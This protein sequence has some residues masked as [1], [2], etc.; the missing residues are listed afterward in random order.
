MS[1]T[2]KKTNR[3]KFLFII[4]TIS[5][6]L[7]SI[8][9]AIN[10]DNKFNN[11]N[12]I[13]PAIAKIELSEPSTLGKI[14]NHGITILDRDETFVSI[15]A[16]DD[17]LIWL[18]NEG[19]EPEILYKDYAEMM[20][21]NTNPK[22]LEDF[23]TYSQMTTDLQGIS[24]TYSDIAQLYNLGSSVQGRTI[25]G[26]KI[27]DNPLIEENEPEVRICGCHHGNEIMS[28]ELSLNLAFYMVE[29]YEND[30]YIKDLVD[31]RE[32]WIIPMVNPDGRESLSRYNAHGVDLNR[33]YGY[34]WDGEGGSPG[35]FSQPETQAIR[36]NALE[37]NFVFSLS[38]HTTANYINYIW[39]YKGQPVKDHNVV[40]YLSQKYGQYNDYIVV[41]GY[42]WYQTRGDTN[43]FS[44][45]CRGDIDWT[46][47]TENSN[48]PYVWNKNRNGMLD[49][50]N[51]ANLGLT[52]I[53]T[54][55][56]T[57][58]PIDA[59][60]WVE[61][62]Y[63]PCFT[64]PILGDYHKPL[65]PGAYNVIIRAN[66]YDEQEYQVVI[67]EDEPTIL[68]VELSKGE[69]R[70]AHQVTWVNFY[71]PYN[72]PNNY[73]NNPT[74]AIFAL[75][76]PD[77]ISAS[78]GVGGVIVLDM[79]EAGEIFNSEGDDFIV[80][81]GDSS[82]DGYTVYISENWDGPW[83]LLA[84]GSG[85][86][87]FDLEDKDIMRARFLKIQDDGNGNPTEQ[88]PGFDLDA[89]ENLN[90]TEVFVDNDFNSSTPGWNYDHFENIQDA[91]DKVAGSG[92]V[93]VY[94][95]T[96]YENIIV[97]KT[98]NLIGQ[99]RN[100]TNIDG[101]NI[102]N[103]I[104][105][106]SNRVNINNFYIKNS[107]TDGS[108]YG[109]EINS[110][111]CT[112]INNNIKNNRIGVILNDSYNHNIVY[113]NNFIDNYQN[114]IDLGNNNQWNN[115][116]PIGGNYWDDYTG[117]DNNS[118]GIGD[119]PYLISGGNSQDNYPFIKP[120]GWTNTPPNK[121]TIIGPPTGATGVK[122]E[123]TF[124]SIDPDDDYL[125]YSINWGDGFEDI[126]GE[127]PS[128]TQANAFHIWSEKGNL[129]IKAKAIDRNG[130]ESEWEQFTVSIP[131]NK[132]IFSSFIIRILEMIH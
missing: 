101:N 121:P 76:P 117:T 71:D 29:N 1:Y 44:Y 46:I 102:G 75:G 32:T 5:L 122:Y 45:G 17:E 53:V 47:E 50:I 65:L 95:G 40:V 34:M 73:Q 79:G 22:L 78:L 56:E 23:H 14:I 82:D 114:A 72:Y 43:D 28:V 61:E 107:G 127:F 100:N 128:G 38:Y 89:I 11:Y 30:P 87:V 41:E 92:N 103:V 42:D 39:N 49:I 109:I 84:T 123:Y 132:S 7:T 110:D 64:D 3:K 59:T 106:S 15:F 86:T 85:T 91:I 21:W 99:D 16:T 81:E 83:S 18:K 130:G 51:A 80:Y 131:R 35:P 13:N 4:L 66:G 69:N 31:N 58:L 8:T 54:D 111:Y 96:Y 24:N 88:N 116:Y 97:D 33:D 118:D 67:D 120:I 74:E 108:Y 104:A 105:I 9:S 20:G 119:T 70:Y 63:W 124:I 115:D 68:N 62:V 52:G 126:I 10:V 113:Y 93:N 27:T 94:E 25:W 90:P 129:I 98:V 125:S 12:F 26:L 55:S 77:E 2:M 60:I 19:L 36:S 112:I 6:I 37:N 48:I 57:G